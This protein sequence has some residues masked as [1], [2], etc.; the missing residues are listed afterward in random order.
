MFEIY[1]RLTFS[2]LY[3]VVDVDLTIDPRGYQTEKTSSWLERFD[4]GLNG[5][6]TS[7]AQVYNPEIVAINQFP[8]KS[9][10][11]PE[12]ELHCHSDPS[13]DRVV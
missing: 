9:W 13:I 3:F 5:F 10:L 12:E 2:T 8:T 6:S 4:N 1:C 7:S 11:L